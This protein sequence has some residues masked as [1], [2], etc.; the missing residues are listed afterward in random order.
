L[1]DCLLMLLLAAGLAQPGQQFPFFPPP[2]GGAPP[3]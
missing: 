3:K 1:P 2:D